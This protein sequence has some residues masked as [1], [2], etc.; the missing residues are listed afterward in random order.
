MYRA[1]FVAKMIQQFDSIYYLKC[2]WAL[3]AKTATY[4]ANKR[5]VTHKLW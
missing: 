1:I 4:D 3:T 5:W 2:Q